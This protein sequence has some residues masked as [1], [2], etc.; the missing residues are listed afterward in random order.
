MTRS[1]DGT[2]VDLAWLDELCAEALWAPTAG[3][4]AGVRFHIVDADHVDDYFNVAT[5]AAWRHESRRYEGLRRAGAVV[6][7]TTRP[8][9]Y[10]KRYGEADKSSS[11]LSDR[12]A[13]PLPYWHTD[14]AMATMALLLLIEEGGWRA[15]LWGN[16]RHDDDVRRWAK[17]DDEELFA[18]VLVGRGDG[19]DSASGSLSR[20]VPSREARVS[21]VF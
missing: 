11:G 5:D 18:S 9:D 15:A 7:I 1:F 19:N 8:G 4:T 14:A 20:P 21:R 10:L 17:L 13:W 3:N 16:F 2:P 12:D 6:L